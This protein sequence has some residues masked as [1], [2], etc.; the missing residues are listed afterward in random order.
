MGLPA[1]LD[2]LASDAPAPGGGSVSALSGALGAALVSMVCRLSRQ[3]GELA[4]HHRLYEEMDG[5][6]MRLREELTRL[7]DRDAE[8]FNGVMA[9]FTLP[10]ATGDEKQAR[11]AAIQAGYKEAIA[12]P[13]ETAEACLA[14]AALAADLAAAFNANAA[15]DLGVAVG[16]AETGLRGALMN[17][18]INLPA[19]KDA[20]Y[21]DGIRQRRSAMEKEMALHR[22][23][24]EKRLEGYV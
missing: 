10:K 22:A 6:A 2:I 8:A 17:V 19:V 3:R 7:V 1:L 15:S 12:V 18:G 11:T 5:R 14:V 20:A 24:A 4:E 16:C 9:A 23:L 13:L 21:V